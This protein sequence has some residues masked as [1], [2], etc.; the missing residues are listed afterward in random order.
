MRRPVGVTE[1]ADWGAFCWLWCRGFCGGMLVVGGVVGL[2]VV[3]RRS[4]LSRRID[5]HMNGITEYS[6]I[7]VVHM[8]M[9]TYY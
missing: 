2:C 3:S 1:S 4:I 7:E 8:S 6:V 5:R 9:Q